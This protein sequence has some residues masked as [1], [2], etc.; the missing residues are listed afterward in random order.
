[1]PARFKLPSGSFGLI[2]RFL[3]FM[4]PDRW[5][6]AGAAALMMVEVPFSVVRPLI[7]RHVLDVALPASDMSLVVQ[8]CVLIAAVSIINQLLA[9]AIGVVI[10][11]FH[12]RFSFRVRTRI[13]RHFQALPLGW[14]SDKDTGYLMS[15][16]TDD[17]DNLDGILADT[18][19]RA[20]MDLVRALFFVVMLL[21]LDPYLAG[22]A[23]AFVTTIF[24]IQALFSRRLRRASRETRETWSLSS[25]SLHD[26][27]S[28]HAL[29]RAS[30]SEGAERSRFST[31]LA[32]HLRARFR[33]DVLGMVAGRISGVVAGIGMG[34]ILFIGSWRILS[35]EFTIGGLFAFFLYLGNLFGTTYALAGLNP[36][37]QRALASAERIAQLL[38]TIPAIKS[39]VGAL[40]RVISEGD[41]AF[42]SVEF[43]YRKGE[44][45]LRGVSLRAR[46]GSTVALVGPSGAGKS[47]FA[48][49]VPRFYDVDS[50]RVSIDGV[51]VRQMRLPDLRGQIGVVPQ[52]IFLFN[53]SVRDNLT[54]G[55]GRR[56]IDMETIEA[57]AEA[58][59]AHAFVSALPQ[60][61]DTLIGERGVRLSGGEKQRL[62][63]AR[64][65]LRNPRVLILDEAT[66]S[67]DSTSERLVQDAVNQLRRNRT[68]IV[69]AHRL[70]TVLS[71]DQIL[72][73]DAGE[74]VAR[75]T[76][77][78]LLAS[79]ELYRKLYE[80]QFDTNAA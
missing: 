8:L 50:G 35:G 68:S 70:S 59:H 80:T 48:S 14:Y 49:M 45:V 67:L 54:V 53:R 57:A 13:F 46:A 7:A 73:F 3:P 6:L 43:A 23:F 72:V 26:A 39:P 38:D 69:I 47:T 4:R 1:M 20:A 37:I 61:Y 56:K 66:S 44:P 76:H 36:V 79:C 11:R 10:A 24:G 40:K 30:A 5:T 60:G 63:I 32:E 71:A 51:D 17:V 52:E 27:L 31:R 62:A 75:G 55:L 41:V 15:R 77:D 25:A 42:E 12:A 9:C 65:L 74:I 34:L 58:A 29:I 2:R 16:Q 78:T 33:R 64:E 19:I 18:F 28:G 22:T 21:V